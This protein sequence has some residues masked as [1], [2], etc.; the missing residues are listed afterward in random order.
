MLVF[1]SS[2][3]SSRIERDQTSIIPLILPSDIVITPVMFCRWFC[4]S[5]CFVAMDDFVC[6][7]C[8]CCWTVL[9][10]RIWFPDNAPCFDCRWRS[11]CD[12]CCP[13]IKLDLGCGMILRSD[14][15]PV[16]GTWRILPPAPPLLVLLL[17][18]R[19]RK[20]MTHSRFR[21]KPFESLQRPENKSYSSAKGISIS[22]QVSTTKQQRNQKRKKES[23][24]KRKNNIFTTR[25]YVEATRKLFDVDLLVLIARRHKITIGARFFEIVRPPT[26]R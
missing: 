16:V 26:V 17:L 9:S 22:E 18:F 15:A 1:S 7:L 24:R 2:S 4:D 23:I 6:S 5:A 19:K 10:T 3:S 11:C 20:D 14:D 12:W 13:R 25:S 21:K 8:C